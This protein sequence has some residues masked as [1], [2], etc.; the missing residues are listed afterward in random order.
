MPRKFF[1]SISPKPDKVFGSGLS[2]VFGDILHSPWL[3]HLHRNTVSTACFV[4]I[5]CAFLP[6]PGQ[7][8]VAAALSIALRCHL[9]IAMLLV[10]ITNPL[11]I[12]PMYYGA[13]LLGCFLMQLTPISIGA[14]EHLTYELIVREI[15]DIWQ[16]LVLGCLVSGL[17]F[18]SLAYG[19]VRVS[20]RLLVINRWLSRHKRS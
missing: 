8:L 17:F 18:G 2:S 10:W 16:P 19:A 7:M 15:M 1:K 5:F 13:Y 11:T 9:P 4:G 20:W 3:W 14:P 6:I 12:A